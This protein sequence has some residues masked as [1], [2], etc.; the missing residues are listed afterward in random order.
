MTLPNNA[1]PENNVIYGYY[2]WTRLE[3]RTKTIL[4]T[5]QPFKILLI[6]ITNRNIIDHI[7]KFGLG[8]MIS[9]SSNGHV[10]WRQAGTR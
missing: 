2:V 4:Q 5:L 3:I 7:I 1:T 9:V 8:E 6:E 10:N